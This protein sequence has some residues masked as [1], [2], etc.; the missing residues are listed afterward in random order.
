MSQVHARSVALATA[1]DGKAR[2]TGFAPHL[3]NRP[4]QVLKES[5]L[6]LKYK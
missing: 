2:R 3:P 4:V 1:E 5:E 6:F